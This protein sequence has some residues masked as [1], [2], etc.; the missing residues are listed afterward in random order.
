MRVILVATLS[1]FLFQSCFHRAGEITLQSESEPLTVKVNPGTEVIDWV[2]FQGPHRN[3]LANGPEPPPLQDPKD[4]I[5]WQI[6]PRLYSNDR[7]FSSPDK[8]PVI[9]YG[10]LPEGWEQ[11]VPSTGSPPPLLDGYVY[12]VNSITFRGPRPRGLCIYVSNGQIKRYSEHGEDP[13]CGKE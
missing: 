7:E 6:T 9:T 3:R 13:L 8:H 10:H 1:L 5:V 12:T 2:W 4:V 11:M